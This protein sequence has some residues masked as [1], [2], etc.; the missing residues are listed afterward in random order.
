[1]SW[2]YRI[3]RYPDDGTGEVIFGI[4]EAYYNHK[5]DD[6]P[7]SITKYSASSSFKTM[8]EYNQ[9]LERVKDAML[10]PILDYDTLEPIGNSIP[11]ITPW[12]FDNN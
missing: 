8:T 2:N 6:K 7:H 5:N 1:M 9:W 11:E 4:H 3:V 12:R 10:K